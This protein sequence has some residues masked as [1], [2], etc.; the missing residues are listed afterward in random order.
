MIVQQLASDVAIGSFFISQVEVVL[1]RKMTGMLMVYH[2][3]SE[4]EKENG[5]S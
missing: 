5:L 1:L 2:E 4:T 3:F